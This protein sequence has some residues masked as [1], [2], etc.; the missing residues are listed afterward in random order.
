MENGKNNGNEIQLKNISQLSHMQFVIPDYQRGYRWDEIQAGQLLNDICEFY[1]SQNK[2]ETG[3][4]YCLQPVVIR[5]RATGEYEVIDGQ[6][7]LTTIF[8]ILKYLSDEYKK[9]YPNF[10]LYSLVYETRPN[11]AN[12]LENIG[13]KEVATDGNIDFYFMQN[14]HDVVKKWFE[15]DEDKVGKCKFLKALLSSKMEENEHGIQKDSANNVRILWY[16]VAD[17]NAEPIELFTRLNIGKIPLTNSELVKA[18]L[19]S[20]RNLT[21]QKD[22]FLRFRI[23][24]E[25]NMMEQ[26]LQNDSFWHFI[27]RSTNNRIYD[28][29]IEFL[30]DLM[31]NRSKSEDCEF[32]HTFNGFKKEYDDSGKKAEAVWKTIKDYFLTLEEWYE[33][34]E[35]YHYIGFL[36]EYGEDIKRLCEES[37]RRTKDD[38]SLHINTRIQNKMKD[39]NLNE[40]TYSDRAKVRKILLL[41]N[42]LTILEAS[43]SE[44]RFPFDKYKTENWDLE[45]ICSQTDKAPNTLNEWKSWA[46]ELLNFLS[47]DSTDS[48][49]DGQNSDKEKSFIAGL[50]KIMG[51]AETR[52]GEF[53]QLLDDISKYYEDG[54]IED[55]DN[56][57]NLTLLDSETNRSYGNAIFPVKRMHIINNDKCGE[58]VPIVTKNVFLKYYSINVKKMMH[59][60]QKDAEF[61]LKEMGNK[62]GNYFK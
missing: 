28:N 1:S 35:L 43:K 61:Y 3:E 33:D 19:L 27:C 11:S 52:S 17:K 15:S 12:F 36:I 46:Q 8:I 41:F 58:F 14:V 37:K 29:R 23:A 10:Q 7:R 25:W 16:E 54:K 38:F 57:S 20:R 13:T 45:H 39:C 60:T 44:I 47:P 34:R 48:N 9:D 56:I 49:M 59:W 42:I 18:L 40:L 6:Q 31:Q 55:R 50:E 30:L 53:K 2:E 21:E 22:D 5:Q 51:A 24:T 32:Y 62:L 4:F 26:K